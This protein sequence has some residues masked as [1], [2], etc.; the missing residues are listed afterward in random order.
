MDEQGKVIKAADV[1]TL[2]ETVDVPP[3]QAAK[4]V[5]ALPG[6]SAGGGAVAGSA[7]AGGADAAGGAGAR[8]T[9]VEA[10]V[11]T[12]RVQ[13]SGLPPGWANAWDAG[14]QPTPRS[15]ARATVA[16]AARLAGEHSLLGGD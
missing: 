13:A 1:V 14:R 9:S 5:E 6:A 15:K 16:A 3:E 4:L 8:P 12:Q 11:G 10:Q 2:L 7:P